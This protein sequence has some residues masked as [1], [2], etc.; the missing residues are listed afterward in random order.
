MNKIEQKPA[1]REAEK[2]RARYLDG[3]EIEQI[4]ELLKRFCEQTQSRSTFDQ[5]N[6]LVARLTN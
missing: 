3:S 5:I 2:P 4:V 1:G 6:S